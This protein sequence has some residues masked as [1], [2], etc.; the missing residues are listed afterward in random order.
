MGS[1]SISEE[2]FW[3]MVNTVEGQRY[4]TYPQANAVDMYPYT[5]CMDIAIPIQL[6]HIPNLNAKTDALL[7]RE[8][9]QRTYFIDNWSWEEDLIKEHSLFLKVQ[10]CNVPKDF[11]PESLIIFQLPLEDIP[12]YMKS[13]DPVARALVSLRLDYGI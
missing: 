5:A 12:L 8:A 11:L 9:T 3:E 10:T 4:Y 2:G 6:M 13:E 1:S 7:R